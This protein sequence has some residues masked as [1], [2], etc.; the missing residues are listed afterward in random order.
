MSGYPISEEMAQAK[1]AV[2]RLNSPYHRDSVT[3]EQRRATR[4]QLNYVKAKQALAKI[5]E[6]PYG[7]SPEQRAALASSLVGSAVQA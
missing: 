7:L 1:A 5:E 4:Q 2:A 3:E 6:S